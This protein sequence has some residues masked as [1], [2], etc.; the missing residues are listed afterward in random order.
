[1]IGSKSFD[2]GAK[3]FIGGMTSSDNLF[4]GGFSS[5]STGVNLLVTPGVLSF[6][7]APVDASTNLAGALLA[8]CED[9]ALLGE[10]KLFLSR[11][12]NGDGKY[13]TYSA[14][15]GLTLKRTDSTNGYIFGA[16]DMAFYQGSAF[17][18][19]DQ[20]VVK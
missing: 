7:P 11:S 12:S 3:E 8:S 10:E 16:S 15:S 19:S 1:M 17:A 4:D 6:A 9:A 14:G 5:R 2:I 20:A 18:T 13:Y